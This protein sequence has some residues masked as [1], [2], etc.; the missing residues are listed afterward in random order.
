M[1]AERNYGNTGAQ[2]GGGGIWVVLDASLNED[3]KFRIGKREDPD[4]E[5]FTNLSGYLDRVD[6]RFSDGN[7]EKKI[8]P[9][10]EFVL[11]MSVRDEKRGEATAGSGGVKIAQYNL[12]LRST[13]NTMLPAVLNVLAAVD[14]L[15]WNGYLSLSVY[16]K[17]GKPARLLVKTDLSQ[18]NGMFPDVKYPFD[19]QT[20]S[21]IGVPKPVEVF[22]Q[23]GNPVIG[24]DGK[25]KL[26]WTSVRNFWLLVAKEIYASINGTPYTGNIGPSSGAGYKAGEPWGVGPQTPTSSPVPQNTQPQQAP[27]EPSLKSETFFAGLK[28]KLNGIQDPLLAKVA[29]EQLWKEIKSKTKLAEWGTTEAEVQKFLLEHYIVLTG[30]KTAVWLPAGV[31]SVTVPS[32][33]D[34][35]PF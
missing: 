20:F 5:A 34:S 35:L 1:S 12:A 16:R 14:P 17:T 29:L 10:W 23:E 26:N 2:D 18:G 27:S 30:D 11:Q 31:I 21:W 19:E 33:N 7:A 8:L 3:P 6:L 25:Q 15:S 4:H 13:H 28:N 9:G 32:S 24:E 22:D